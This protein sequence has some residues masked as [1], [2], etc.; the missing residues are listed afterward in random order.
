[1][2][3]KLSQFADIISGYSFRGAIPVDKD[4]SYKVVQVRDIDTIYLDSATIETA[5]DIDTPPTSAIIQQNDVLLAMRGTESSGLKVAM[6]TDTT[7]MCIASSSLCILRV[8]SDTVLPEYVLHYLHSFYGQRDLVY[9]L[10]G[11][12]VKTIVK[13]ELANMPIPIPSMKK[14][15]QIV[16]AAK[17]IHDQQQLLSKKINVLTALSDN[18]ISIHA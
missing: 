8:T 15:Q 7:G 16:Q 17:N 14:Q 3:Q 10:S 9:L 18:I 5:A 4:G 6:I 1:M 2:K 12:T 13:K 11:A